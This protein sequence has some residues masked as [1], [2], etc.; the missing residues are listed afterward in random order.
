M[1]VVHMTYNYITL[2]H[3]HKICATV[4]MLIANLQVPIPVDKLS[5][6]ILKKIDE[7][8]LAAQKSVRERKYGKKSD[9]K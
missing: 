8:K 1:L 7:W 4:Y 9:K 5:Q 6:K 2:S 3:S